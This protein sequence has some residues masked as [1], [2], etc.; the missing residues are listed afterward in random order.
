MTTATIKAGL[1]GL[2]LH[3]A[4]RF[5]S[6]VLDQIEP[7]KTLVVLRYNVDGF[8]KVKFKRTGEEAQI[9]F[10]ATKDIALHEPPV[11][12]V[13][14]PDV[15]PC[16]IEQDEFPWKGVF[17]LVATVLGALFIA[18]LLLAFGE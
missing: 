2:K 8:T 4:E 1:G 12:P 5:D 10:V 18:G 6:Y 17:W 9:G 13:P 16:V 3:V 7:D 14:P 11:A 15:E